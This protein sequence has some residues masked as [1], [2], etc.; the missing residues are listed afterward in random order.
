MNTKTNQKKAPKQ[1]S[2]AAAH[3]R[4]SELEAKLKEPCQCAGAKVAQLNA[5]P[6]KYQFTGRL[7]MP[8]IGVAMPASHGFHQY[9]NVRIEDDVVEG[10]IVA[11]TEAEVLDLLQEE[12][13]AKYPTYTSLE[14]ADVSLLPEGW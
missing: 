6:Q 7:G 5:T 11:P 3:Q 9:V 4:I 13:K 2:V 14:V 10:V 12:A 1:G 8:T